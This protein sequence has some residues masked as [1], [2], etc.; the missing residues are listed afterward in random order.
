MN[1]T[2]STMSD[3]CVILHFLWRSPPTFVKC[4]IRFLDSFLDEKNNLYS[5]SYIDKPQL[6]LKMNNISATNIYT[7][8]KKSLYQFL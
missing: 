3:S 8:M 1:S 7:Y 6:A 5:Q 4:A 2:D